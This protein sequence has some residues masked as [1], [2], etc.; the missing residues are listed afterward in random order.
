MS[1]MML[2]TKE[3]KTELVNAIKKYLAM[4]IDINILDETKIATN[5]DNDIEDNDIE[6]NDIED[7]D[8]EDNDIV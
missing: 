6:D 8:I 7:N 2:N 3:D 1:I 5:E 4:I